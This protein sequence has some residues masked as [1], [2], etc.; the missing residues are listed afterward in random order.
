MNLFKPLWGDRAMTYS[1]V[2]YFSWIWGPQKY[3]NKYD[4]NI[5]A[6]STN[7]ITVVT[8]LAQSPS[9]SAYKLWVTV[10]SRWSSAL[11]HLALQSNHY[12]WIFDLCSLS[13]LIVYS[14][15]KWQCL[16]VICIIFCLCFHLIFFFIFR[17]ILKK[18][19]SPYVIY[20]VLWAN[21]N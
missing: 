8:I 6:K 5:L 16:F 18:V 2:G 4:K 7:Y 13:D 3:Q 14:Y 9:V 17:Q 1:K 19:F 20:L 15:L 21:P 11:L 10:L 12:K